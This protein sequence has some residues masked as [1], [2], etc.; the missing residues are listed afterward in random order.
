[1]NLSRKLHRVEMTPSSI[2]SHV[3]TWTNLLTS[4]T[5][6]LIATEFN[7]N[8]NLAVLGS[9]FNVRNTPIGIQSKQR[10]I[11]MGSKFSHPQNDRPK[12]P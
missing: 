3:R 4:W 12:Y 2:G 9:K 6:N 10:L 5:M 1:M 7:L 8:V 11:V